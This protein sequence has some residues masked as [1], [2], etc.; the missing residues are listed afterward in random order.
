MKAYLD[1][2]VL[3][4]GGKGGVGKTT[5]ASSF[6]VGA[7]KR[8]K[9][10]LLVSTDPAHNTGDIFDRPIGGKETPIAENLWAIE[11]DPHVESH[12]YIN[13]VK[14]NI[15]QVVSS[16][17]LEEINRQIDVASVSP[18]AEEA[19]LFD[20]LV[21]LILE[22][23]DAYDLIVFDT[24]PTGHTIRLLSLP[25]LMGVWVDGM[26]SRRQKTNEM[27]A[28]LNDGEEPPDDPIY[29]VLQRRKN[30]FARAREILLDPS[31]T[32][33]IFVMIPEKLPM[34]ETKKAIAMLQKHGIPT[35]TIIV[36]RVLPDDVVDPFFQKRKEQEKR[37]LEQMKEMFAEQRLHYIPMME[38]DIYGMD[39]LLKIAGHLL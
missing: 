7:A 20:R 16:R 34:V 29:E 4:F 37:Y 22:G 28:W 27:N 30:K 15:R 9:K 38:H 26:L 1:K 19:A 31:R 24:A 6:A 17:M 18:G 23:Q 2:K 5:S 11:I 33:F 3:F 13:Q 35:E 10:T 39:A 21:D 25:E 36:N 14:D 32:S 8:G 12:R